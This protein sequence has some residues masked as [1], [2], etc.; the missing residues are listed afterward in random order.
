MRGDDAIPAIVLTVDQRGS[1][2]DQDRVADLLARTRALP[3]RLSFRRTAG[4]EAQAL[5][6]EAGDLPAVLEQV[7]RSGDWRVGIGVGEVEKPL[8]HDVREARGPAFVHARA[9][10]EAARQAPATLR[11]EGDGPTGQ[12][13]RA[14][15]SALWLWA[16][17][18]ERRSA[19]GWEVVDLVDRGATYDEAA[20]ALGITQ[21]AVSQR[22][23]AAGLAEGRRAR[24]LVAHLASAALRASSERS[25]S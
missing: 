20:R 21:S 24:E 7:L 9:A 16:A 19:R 2:R 17:L 18:L 4:D 5:V 14:L 10:V 1:R 13:A 22:A 6:T 8:P 11:V 25:G 12:P 15:E 23:R 3:V